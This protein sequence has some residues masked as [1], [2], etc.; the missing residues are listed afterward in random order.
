MWGIQAENGLA[1]KS[2]ANFWQKLARTFATLV[3]DGTIPNITEYQVFYMPG[4]I[5]TGML[6]GYTRPSQFSAT[7]QACSIDV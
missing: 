7:P 5:W 2:M 1:V 3:F 6:N 4:Y